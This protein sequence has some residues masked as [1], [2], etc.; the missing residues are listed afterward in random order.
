MLQSKSSPRK[1]SS[2]PMR[3]SSC[4]RAA[5]RRSRGRA[6]Q[7][8][9]ARRAGARI[10]SC[11]SR[12][13]ATSRGEKRRIS[14]SQRSSS[15]QNWT[16]LPSSKGTKRP[17]VAGV[18]SKPC[19]RSPQLVDHQRMQQADEVGAR[20][21]LD[22]TPELFQRAGAADALRASSTSTRL[23]LSRKIGRACQAIVTRADDDR[24][25][26]VAPPAHARAPADRSCPGRRW[27]RLW[28]CH[29]WSSGDSSSA[30]DR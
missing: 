23:P 6:R 9:A 7:R 19:A 30:G 15:S 5:G 3:S 2:S 26:S 29:H 8:D 16:L 18:Q 27:S 12:Q 25:P 21:H 13:P 22:A 11:I 4:S 24:H 17:L 1:S 28:R 10:T 20:R 14:S